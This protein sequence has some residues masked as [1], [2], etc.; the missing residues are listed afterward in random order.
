MNTEQQQ[1]LEILRA[2]IRQILPAE[3]QDSYEEVQPVSMGSAGLKFAEDGTVAWDQIWGSFCD[4]A[5]AG[6]PPHKGRLLEPASP[7]EIESD[8]AR[9]REI[10]DEIC[11][12]ITL[13][14]ELPAMPAP[15][16]GWVRVNCPNR[17]TAEWLVR[18]IVMENVSAH[19]EDTALYLPAGPRYRLSKEVK[20]VVTS[21]AKTHHYWDGHMWPEQNR[22][23]ARLFAE[24]GAERPL[25]QPAVLGFGFDPGHHAALRDRMASALGSSTG[26]IVSEQDYAGWLGL[27]CSTVAAAIWMMRAL[28]A[29]NVLARREETTLFVP[30]NPI[31]DP[32]GV[33]VSRAVVEIHGYAAATGVREL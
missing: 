21:I 8:A 30:V 4:L 22:A 15:V 12:A 5:M 24:M 10:V 32:Q 11:R 20:N 18:A 27:E 3:Y 1:S 9:Y 2:R 33:A 7:V 19:W 23:I 14:T 6:G 13:V 17:A 25:I 31:T 28:V 29:S 26:L 16:P